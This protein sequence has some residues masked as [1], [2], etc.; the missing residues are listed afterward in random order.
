MDLNTAIFVY[1]SITKYGITVINDKKYAMAMVE[2][3]QR[4]AREFYQKLQ[5]I[6]V[7]IKFKKEKKG[8]K[9]G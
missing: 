4:F 9:N 2:I 6:A 3:S 5:N 7:S 8:R 1:N